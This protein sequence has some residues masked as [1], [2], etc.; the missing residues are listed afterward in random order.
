MEL[1]ART[2]ETHLNQDHSDATP[3]HN[4]SCGGSARYAGRRTKEFVTV[5]GPM[6]LARAYYHCGD[7]GHGFCPRDR[8]LGLEGSSLSPALMR[9]VGAVAS[10]VSFQESSQL[11]EELAG[12]DVGTKQVQ[13][14]AQALGEQVAGYERQTR[15][16]D[17]GLPLPATLYLGLDGTGVPIR[18]T[19]MQGRAGKQ[20][21]GSAPARPRFGHL[22]RGHR[23]RRHPGYGPPA[24][25]VR[26]SE[27]QRRR[28]G[29]APR[30][31][32]LGDGARWIWNL[33]GELFP[34]AVQIVDRFHAKER[35]H[36]LSKS[37]YADRQSGQEWAQQRC[38]ELDAG[39]IETLLSVLATEASHH[40][41]GQAA[42]TYFQENRHRMRYTQFEAQGLCTSTGV[43]E[44]GCKNA[45]GARLKRSGMH[46]SLRGANSIM[47]LRCIRLSGRFEDFWEWRSNSKAAA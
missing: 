40:E 45:I 32:V 34:E 16:P 14:S 38:A 17:S 24:F 33:A 5:L 15:E 8:A 31:V 2:L 42:C 4:C 13:R 36:T 25:G 46:W 9:M 30:Q 12:V 23:E 18:S 47:A 39:R 27:S 37:L 44:A 43:V 28:F 6:R 35:L 11:L 19:E 29:Q 3:S 20:P 26:E 21:D 10:M 7:C 1:A 22:H 41:E